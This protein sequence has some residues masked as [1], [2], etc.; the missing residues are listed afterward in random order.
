MFKSKV[1]LITGSSTGIGAGTAVKFANEGAGGIVLH[2]RQK[3]ALKSVKE[4]CENVGK[5]NVKVH[6]C[7][8]D[9]TKQEVRE[10]LINETIQQFGRL[11]V[12]VNNAGL[13]VPVEFGESKIEIYDQIF[14]VNV[15]SLIILTQLALPHLIKSN[16]NIVNVSSVASVKIFPMMTYYCMSKAALD[17]FTRCLA[18]DLGPKG[19]RVNS[20]NPGAIAGTEL[21]TRHGSGGEQ[22][23]AILK[24]LEQIYPLRRIGTVDEI[25]DAILFLASDKAQF[26]TGV[27]FVVDGGGIHV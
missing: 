24:H 8:G 20:V 4:Q 10:K 18:V 6:I 16:G 15:R 26:I 12:L 21:A 3:D 7:M 2:G 19:V 9:I 22:I 11:D 17:H 13:A 5:G 14:D 23:K 1:I 27:N 25:A